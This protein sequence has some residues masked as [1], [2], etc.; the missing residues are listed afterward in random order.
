MLKRFQLN[1]L[2]KSKNEQ[3]KKLIDFENDIE[4]AEEKAKEVDVI[5]NKNGSSE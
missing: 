5:L 1:W 2:E 3:H 4:K